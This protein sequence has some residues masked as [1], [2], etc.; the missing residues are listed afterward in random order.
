VLL[1]IALAD[2]LIKLFWRWRRRPDALT[3]SLMLTVGDLAGT[4]LM[5]VVFWVSLSK[6]EQFSKSDAT[7][8]ETVWPVSM[9]KSTNYTEPLIKANVFETSSQM[10]ATLP[11]PEPNINP[12]PPVEHIHEDQ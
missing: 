5:A 1:L 4:L 10:N 11:L 9:D 7:I 3:A 6:G 2:W 8:P 12:V